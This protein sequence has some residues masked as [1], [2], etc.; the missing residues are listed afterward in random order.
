MWI[1]RFSFY[2]FHF[3]PYAIPRGEHNVSRKPGSES[4]KSASEVWPSLAKAR[5]ARAGELVRV[6]RAKVLGFNPPGEESFQ[7]VG[8]RY[9]AHQKFYLC[10]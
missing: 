4:L 10:L 6:E 8:E 3:L 1:S 2:F 9:L 7:E 5:T